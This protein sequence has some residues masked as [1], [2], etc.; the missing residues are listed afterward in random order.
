MRATK[1][2]YVAE[3]DFASHRAQDEKSLQNRKWRPAMNRTVALLNIEHFR[4]LL[5]TE[6]DESKRKTLLQL[7][8]EEEA[9]L[10]KLDATPN[11]PKV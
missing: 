10:A 2:L 6:A 5:T 7:L 4:T 11:Q 3:L 9:T 8:A 1:E